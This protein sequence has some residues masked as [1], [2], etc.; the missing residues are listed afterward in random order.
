MSYFQNIR[1]NHLKK[2]FRQKEVIF[3]VMTILS[4]IITLFLLRCDYAANDDFYM[5]L[6]ASGEYGS[7]SQY[8]IFI[9]IIIG[10]FLKFLYSIIPA[11][12]WYVALQLGAIIICFWILSFYILKHFEWIPACIIKLIMFLGFEIPFYTRIQFSQTAAVLCVTGYI[13]LYY[14][15]HKKRKFWTGVAIILLFFGG[16][17]R[18]G[19][20]KLTT[21]F[22]VGMGIWGLISVFRSESNL[23][24]KGAVY[25]WIKNEKI[26][27]ILS[28]L[29]FAMIFGLTAYNTECYYRSESFKTYKEY[30][31]YISNITDYKMAD[32][33]RLQDKYEEAGISQEEYIL[34]ENYILADFEVFDNI[35]LQKII[36]IKNYIDDK[37]AF[38][39]NV[40][41]VIKETFFIDDWNFLYLEVI[42]VGIFLMILVK[43]RYG[44]IKMLIQFFIFLG[45]ILFFCYIGRSRVYVEIGLSFFAFTSMV[46]AVEKEWKFPRDA[47]NRIVVALL[48][49][50]IMVG[51]IKDIR[52]KWL[53]TENI[54]Q[55]YETDVEE[56]Y[57]YMSANKDNFYML[58]TNDTS[59]EFYG[60]PMNYQK[61][62]QFCL[63]RYRLGDW[64]VNTP[65]S[66]KILE[67]YGIENPIECMIT[68]D[69]VFFVC[70][71]NKMLNELCSY[72]S[73]EYKKDT[74]Y[75]I[76][77]QIGGYQI[78]KFSVIG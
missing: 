77:E 67:E 61:G 41:N 43:N 54:K 70:R 29:I 28:G 6:I 57:S 5:M 26:Y 72:Y 35:E 65:Y 50:G 3:R 51:A 20:Y 62:S 7:D 53:D 31:T 12:N 27:I 24:W 49:I 25:C 16:L 8:L 44:R 9:N 58:N 64:M 76:L 11:F 38:L 45:I 75:D 14:G 21:V 30:R 2:N 39:S 47:G 42:W 1:S 18:E 13:L 68:M 37:D 22:A 69:N 66:N 55:I 59:Y 71:D 60:F 34:L 10:Y 74:T 17:Y 52:E 23:T 63:N 36:D 4:T 56:L 40:S 33:G 48:V 78:V 73:V 32:W 46:L 19:V 15:T